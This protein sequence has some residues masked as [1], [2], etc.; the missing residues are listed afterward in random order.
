MP[1][2][3]LRCESCGKES[4]IMAS[5]SDKMEQRI[6]CPECGSYNMK[7]VYKSA[8]FFIKSD[9]SVGCPNSHVCGNGCC[10]AH[11]G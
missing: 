4:N 6:P 3:D 5:I 2:Y 9:K 1:F 11:G 7:T 8:P 10:H